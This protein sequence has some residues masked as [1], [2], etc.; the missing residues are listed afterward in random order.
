M[1]SKTLT[2]ICLITFF[3]GAHLQAQ[4]VSDVQAPTE[5]YLSP[6]FQMPHV[7]VVPLATGLSNPYALAFRDNGD[8]LITERYTGKLRVIR[9]GELLEEDIPGVPEVYAG[10]FRA[11]LMDI[12][13]HPDDDSLIYL[14]YLKPLTFGEEPEFTVA[15]ARGRLV[16]DR[17]TEVRDIF[18]AKDPDPA[19]S[20]AVMHFAPDNT[21]FLSV[22]GA[23]AYLGVGELAQ[24]T[25]SQYGKLLRFNDDGSIPQ[26]NPF[27]ASGEFLPE[28]YSVGHRNQLGMTFHPET[29]ELW[30]S[31]NGPQGGDEIN[32]IHAGENY[33]WPLVSFSRHY[34]GD[35]VAETPGHNDF[36]SPEVLFWPS[37][38]PAEITFYTGDKFPRWQ[39]NLFVGSMMKG[40]LPETGHLVRIAFN[41]RGQ[42]IRREE[43]LTELNSRIREVQQGPDGYLYV[44]TDE[45][46]GALLRLEPAD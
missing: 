17:L 41:S 42:E 31:E 32:I 15:L 24:D 35:W 38:A 12:V 39:G 44:L 1:H 7:R 30:A 40:R 11:G 10:E 29:G 28:V 33:G 19:A 8:M 21:L 14:S 45:A 6:A 18:V 3:A 4:E 23:A 36:K 43:L 2:G 16:E 26:D 46:D 34:R 9:D 20:A 37:I 27:V 5:P 13:L 25:T 22:G